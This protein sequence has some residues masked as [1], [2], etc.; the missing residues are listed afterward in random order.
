VGAEGY[1]RGYWRG[2]KLQARIYVLIILVLLIAATYEVIIAV[3]AI[4]ALLG[5]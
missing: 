4:P 5:G 2:L 3:F 1:L